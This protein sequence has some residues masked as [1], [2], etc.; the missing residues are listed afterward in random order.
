[1]KMILTSSDIT[2][3]PNGIETVEKLV[4]KNRQDI[5]IA[6]INEASAVDFGGHRWAIAEMEHLA[7]DFGG[8]IEIVHLLAISKEQAKE[9]IEI[10]DVVLV[11]GGNS[12]YLKTVFDKTGFSEY[13]PDILEKKLYIGSSAGSMILGHRPT[14]KIWTDVYQE[15]EY[16]DK[17]FDFV[18]LEFLPHFHSPYFERKGRVGSRMIDYA[19]KESKISNCPI[20]AVSDKAAVVIDGDNIL[21]IGDDYLII[22]NGEVI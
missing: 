10:A 19:V 11:L 3:V 7:R 14:T 9:R 15:T 21:V 2:G 1:M 22:E 4:G 6:I 18:E 16:A 17:F 13:L 20:Y 12:D 8:E 5:N